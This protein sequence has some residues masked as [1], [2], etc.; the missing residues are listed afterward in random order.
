MTSITTGLTEGDFH[1]LGVLSNGSMTDILTLIG[2]GGGGAGVTDVTSQSSELTVAT[3]GTTRQLS[4][5]LNAYA[6]TTSVSTL[7]ANCVLASAYNAAMATKIDSVTITAPL[8]ISGTGSSRA[9]ATL[10]KPSTLAV[11]T[12]LFALAN[13]ALGTVSLSLTGAESRTALKLADTNAVVRDLTS[14]ITG[15]LVWNTSQLVDLNYL[16]AQ[17]ALKNDVISGLTY[18]SNAIYHL[19]SNEG[20]TPPLY[21]A[22][23]PSGGS[24]TNQT[25][26]QELAVPM[27]YMSLGPAATS[28][29][30]TYTFDAKA[31]TVSSLVMDAMDT[32]TWATM[33]EIEF[34]LTSSW[35]THT[36]T[37]PAFAN[38]ALDLHLGFSTSLVG[39]LYTQPSG[40]VHIRN[41]SLT[42]P[43]NPSVRIASDLAVSGNISCVNLT[44]TSD[45]RIKTEVT[46]IDEQARVS[47]IRGVTPKN[48]RRTDGVEGVRIG[49]IS[50]EIR[51]E[52]PE[53]W[54]N[55]VQWQAG[56]QSLLV[57][58]YSRLV[59]PLWASV[60][61]LLARVEALEGKN[62]KASVSAGKKKT[63]S[64]TNDATKATA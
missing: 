30:Y 48:Y 31:G 27:V 2:A 50:Q 20:G 61:N 60:R 12:G 35:V 53:D 28:G 57:L 64:N 29:N 3:S 40:T 13:D 25:G 44:Q 45:R 59:V 26:Y 21:I 24:Y 63:D 52:M 62:L 55:L 41:F 7:L 39:G 58:Q 19:Q 42:S 33:F 32:V 1:R 15:G 56:E 38:G 47:L 6:T 4:L 18:G 11:S 14:T 49:F 22:W 9:L 43:G 37:F 8:A 54:A 46:D 10:W 23:T 5:T 36:G 34:N 17:M 51:D 16:V